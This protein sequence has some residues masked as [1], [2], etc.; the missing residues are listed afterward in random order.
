V[1]LD[2]VFRRE[3]SMTETVPSDSQ[4]VTV[5]FQMPAP[6]GAVVP[7]FGAAGNLSEGWLM[8]DGSSFSADTYPGLSA[9]LGKT[10]TPDLRGYF[11]RGLDPSGKV[12]PEGA[13]RSTGS[14]Q[15]DE[16]KKHQH[17]YS[18]WEFSGNINA[19]GGSSYTCGLFA[20]KTDMEGGAD[21][22]RP[23]NVAVNYIIFAGLP[24]NR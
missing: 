3:L 10:T 6:I 16:F 17:G 18:A 24:G 2:L 14:V 15:P 22:T 12:D 19:A 20:R 1:R 13:G 4:S 8:C 11:L 5:V 9:L 21:E 7:F 23:K